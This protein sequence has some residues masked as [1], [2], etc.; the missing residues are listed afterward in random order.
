MPTYIY[1]CRRCNLR[2]EEKRGYH[3]PPREK[4]IDPDCGGKVERVIQSTPFFFKRKK[5]QADGSRVYD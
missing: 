5:E 4:C 1:K 2:F 3:D